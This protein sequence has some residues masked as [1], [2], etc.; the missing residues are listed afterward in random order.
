MTITQSQALEALRA[1]I[2]TAT[3]VEVILARYD[4]V[5]P[6]SPYVTVD[7]IDDVLVGYPRSSLDPTYTLTALRELR[8]QVTGYGAS[9]GPLLQTAAVRLWTP[10][11]VV[12]AAVI[13]A[14][15]YPQRL[16][17]LRQVTAPYRTGQEPRWTLDVLA[18]YEW[19][20]VDAEQGVDASIAVV[21]DTHARGAVDA[22]A[23]PA[24]AI[25]EVPP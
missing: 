18:Q 22:D 2:A 21:V 1:A 15:V 16:T 17:P 3:G 23:E 24:I 6:A 20:A 9:A 10:D 8:V 25:P 7:V 5:R 4:A 14:G 12:G 19:A 13:A 11:D